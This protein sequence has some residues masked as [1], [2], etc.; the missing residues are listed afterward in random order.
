M[1]RMVSIAATAAGSPFFST[2][3][4]SQKTAASAAT[5]FQLPLVEA[6]G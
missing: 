2:A 6:L 3:V 4:D 5:G 1:M